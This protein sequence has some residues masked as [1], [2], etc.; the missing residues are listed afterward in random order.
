LTGYPTDANN[1]EWTAAHL[2]WFLEDV[3]T[4]T[5]ADVI[6][7][8]AHSMGNRPLVSAMN[9]IAAESAPAIRARFHE[10]ILT[11]P[12]I[13]AA[14]FRQ[15]AG[16]L[17]HAAQHV[18]LYASSNDHALQASREYQGYQ[19]AGDTQPSVV[20][21]DGVDTIDVSAV[22]TGL[23]GHSYFADKRSV[24]ADLYYLLRDSVRPDQRAGLAPSGQ[25]PTRYW[26]FRP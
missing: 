21:V 23:L 9:R 19:R 6:Q 12:D 3:A 22:D 18:T 1:A 13:D 8:I 5:H 25:P 17:R 20:I 2:R 11:A 16:S 24:I 15:V 7:V 26:I 10:V 4:K 14:V